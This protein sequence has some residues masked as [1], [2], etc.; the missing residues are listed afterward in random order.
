VEKRI[1]KDSLEKE[2]GVYNVKAISKKLGLQPGTLRAW[3]RRYNIVTPKRNEVG[4][5]IYTENDLTKL[6]WLVDKVQQGFTISQA[7]DLLSEETND[8]SSFLSP[9]ESLNLKKE[10]ISHHIFDAL[11]SLNEV[12][13]DD[14]IN[15]A[16]NF[17]RIEVVILDILAPITEPSFSKKKMIT[18]GELEY[19]KN[20]I[21]V[22]IL[23]TYQRIPIQ[24]F[25]PKV[26]TIA[27][28]NK[29][30]DI[31]ILIFS[32]FLK[33][34]GFQVYYVGQYLD[35]KPL[36]Q[37]LQR[38]S[39]SFFFSTDSQDFIFSNHEFLSWIDKDFPDINVGLLGANNKLYSD[40]YVGSTVK[41]WEIWL[42][43]RL[44]DTKIAINS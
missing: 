42:N 33:L 18:E 8:L 35:K 40:Y 38:I 30:D 12:E 20:W 17:Y 1:K 16:L 22:K 4:H 5:R 39:P 23:S 21:R 15:Y 34:R 6:K 25:L 41:E 7:V 43:K 36:N 24:S 31:K 9:G 3:E 27:P 19:I 10:E 2:K 28:P 13:A 44:G 26:L 14:L 29:N 37:L 32:V 11:L